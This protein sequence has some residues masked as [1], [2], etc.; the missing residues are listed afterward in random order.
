MPS[1]CGAGEYYWES[2]GQQGGQT[3][4]SWGKSTVN[5]H[6]KDWC[7]SWSSTILV[8]WSEQS[9]LWKKVPDA[10]KDWGWKQKRASE[11]E[12]TGWNHWC[13]GHE[14]GQSSGD[15]EGRASMA[16]CSLWGGKGL[17]TVVWLN[18]NTLCGVFPSGSAVEN[19][20]QCRRLRCSPWVGKSPWRRS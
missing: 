12:M 20:L 9:T 5:T 4:Q 1:K 14:L 8:T 15:G 11:D 3:S 18:S 16:C 13:N 7:W 2:F 10:G 19:P 17:D 6:W